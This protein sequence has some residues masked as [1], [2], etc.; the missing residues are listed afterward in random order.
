MNETKYCN[1]CRK[2]LSVNEF[3]TRPKAKGSLERVL[4]SRCKKCEALGGE[5]YRKGNPD[6]V[7]RARKEYRKENLSRVRMWAVRT[8]WKK[9]GFDPDEVEKFIC[10]RQPLCEI[11]GEKANGKALAVDHCHRTNKLRGL[12][13]ENCNNGLGRFKDSPSLLRKAASYLETSSA[14][15]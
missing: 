8:A 2:D 13:C 5:K 11:C 6:K 14:S 1:G 12:L 3:R 4:R 15:M 9:R 7:K 10:S